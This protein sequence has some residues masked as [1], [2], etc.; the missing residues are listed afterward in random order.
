MHVGPPGGHGG[1][2]HRAVAA[3]AKAQPAEH[4]LHLAD[5]QRNAGEPF[6][7][8]EAE[9]DHP[10]RDR[11]RTRDDG[12]R[13]RAA[14]EI[15]HHAGR[16]L[17][18]RN[19]EGGIDAA[20]EAIARIGVDGELAAGV[21]DGELIPQ[22]RLDQHV[23]GRLRAAARLAAH[24]AGERFDTGIVGDD[25]HRLVERIGLAVEREQSFA[26][27]GAAHHEIALHLGGV[28]HVQRPATVVGDE[29]RDIDQRIDRPQP[30]RGEPPLQ[31][32]RARAIL[33]AAH[34]AQREAAAQRRRRAEVEPH[35]DRAR[36]GAGDGFDR[37]VLERPHPGGGEIAGDAVHAGGVGT[38][39][40]QVDLDDGIVEMRPFGIARAER[41]IGRQVEDAV[42]IVRDLQ[43]ERRNQHAPALDAA[44]GADAE[45]DVLARYERARRREHAHHAGPR[46]GRAAHDLHRSARP[47]VDHADAQPVG[48]GMLLGRDHARDRE[49]RQGR[50]LVGDALDLEPDHGQAIDQRGER[51]VGREMLLEP[52]Q[53]EF[54]RTPPPRHSPL[55][56]RGERS[57]RVS[58]PGE[59]RHRTPEHLTLCKAS[60]LPDPPPHAGE[61]ARGS[62]A[63]TLPTA[64]IRSALR[65]GSGNR[66]GGSRSGRANARRP[67]RR[68]AGRACRI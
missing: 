55:P 4:A 54:H 7:L 6:D 17:E 29:V 18:A 37:L 20:L 60:P 67:R 64:L 2:D 31:P 24:D 38:V 30:D 22:R 40:R 45:R 49:R 68:G 50:R 16:E 19:H 11:Q 53:R 1:T 56:A 47:G 42:V 14:A 34:E 32:L 5:G 41:R 10:F 33:D 36:P 48:I 43:L 59:G 15:E 57:A 9:I 13:R 52:G 23:G 35:T 21:G 25:A 62:N 58:A 26:R 66:A 12:L 51:R 46:I 3:Q 63:R 39:G 8:I 28:E 44:N 61:G 27:L 65:R